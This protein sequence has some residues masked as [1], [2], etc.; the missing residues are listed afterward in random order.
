M[1]SR[2]GVRSIAPE[3]LLF[4]IRHDAHRSNRLKE[5][6]CWKDVRKNAKPAGAG[7]TSSAN[8]NG[9]DDSALVAEIEDDAK[10]LAADV[11]SKESAPDRMNSASKAPVQLG[12]K[13]RQIGLFWDLG[14]SLTSDLPPTTTGST[15]LYSIISY[16]SND[17]EIAQ[18]DAL[19]RLRQ[20]DL[21]TL[22]MTQAEYMEYSECRQASFTFK[23]GR[24]FREWLTGGT[25]RPGGLNL[26][27]L[28]SGSA[29]DLARF[30]DDTLEILGFLAYEMVQKLTEVSLTVKYESECRERQNIKLPCDSNSESRSLGGLFTS[31]LQSSSSST[32]TATSS[33][34][35]KSS[36]SSLKTKTPIQVQHVEEGYRR[37]MSVNVD[38]FHLFSPG[39]N[40]RRKFLL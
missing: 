15:E 31:K 5:F 39:L 23:K 11:A 29:R 32:K 19:R 34:T 35:V 24:K 8:P 12:P 20:A 28:A 4:L 36:S 7:G 16:N 33:A 30:N 18:R 2:R 10:N 14:H 21:R 17:Q 6:L 25:A 37:I 1:V 27:S 9:N 26:T 13:R 22:S 40:K 38:S 3:D